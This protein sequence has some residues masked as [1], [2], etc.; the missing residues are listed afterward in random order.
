MHSASFNHVVPAFAHLLT[1]KLVFGRALTSRGRYEWQSYKE[2]ATRA[3]NIAAG[4]IASGIAPGQD[5]II[6]VISANRAE[7]VIYEQAANSQSMVLVP[8][9]STLG[10]DVVEYAPC[11]PFQLSFPVVIH[12]SARASIRLHP[13]HIAHRNT[14]LFHRTY[15]SKP[16]C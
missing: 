9:Y 11:L 4:L 2:V 7:W 12:P 8:L 3:K 13:H 5:S 10:A 1:L 15:T 14:T 16:L 6:G